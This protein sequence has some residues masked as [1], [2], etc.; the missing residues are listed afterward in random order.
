MKGRKRPGNGGEGGRLLLSSLMQTVSRAT[1]KVLE[2][3]TQHFLICVQLLQQSNNTVIESYFA[4][5]LIQHIQNS[6]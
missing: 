3:L 5:R 4:Q 2:C 1:A 6:G